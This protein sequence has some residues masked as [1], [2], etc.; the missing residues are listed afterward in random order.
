MD[1]RG[2]LGLVEVKLYKSFGT[3][4]WEREKKMGL[5]STVYIVLNLAF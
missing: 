5:S 2:I 1:F 3:A 4:G